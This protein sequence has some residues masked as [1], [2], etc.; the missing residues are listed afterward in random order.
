MKKKEIFAEKKVGIWLNQE[1]AYIF[2]ITGLAEPVM[3]KIKSAVEL[4][5]RFSGEKEITS[6][7]LNFIA[8]AKE[9]KQRR[10]QQ[11]R[12]DYF[13]DIIRHITDAQYIY[14]FGPSE[15]KHGLLHAIEKDKRVLG[16][17][18]PLGNANR[19]TLNQMKEKIKEYFSGID[20][21]TVK[22]EQK[23]LQKG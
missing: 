15:A 13:K 9:K 12:I 10:Q 7:S 23:K 16:N 5:V 11:E 21:R 14:I 20:F 8:G 17:V 19:M 4:H 22:K 6:R 1:K 2:K 3:E 18:L